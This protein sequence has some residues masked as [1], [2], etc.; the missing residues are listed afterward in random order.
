[1]VKKIGV[2]SLVSGISG[3]VLTKG[4]FA[5]YGKIVKQEG[6]G[7]GR[8]RLVKWENIDQPISVTTRRLEPHDPTQDDAHSTDS[9]SSDSEDSDAP[10]DVSEDPPTP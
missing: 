5:R 3:A 9:P 2:G 1:M 10:S 8:K 4:T 7:I 6:A